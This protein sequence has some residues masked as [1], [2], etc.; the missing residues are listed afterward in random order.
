MTL[1]HGLRQFRVAQ[2]RL[3]LGGQGKCHFQHDQLAPVG[4]LED[5]VA[6]GEAAGVAVHVKDDAA[7]AVHDAHL[8]QIILD[9]NAI[10]ANI[11]DRRRAHRAGD[12]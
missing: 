9:F 5:A 4:L 8:M 3:P 7:G 10:R 11:L 2:V 12:Q 1:G 6:V